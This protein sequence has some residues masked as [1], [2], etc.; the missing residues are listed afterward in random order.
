MLPACLFQCIRVLELG[1]SGDSASAGGSV[2]TSA[3]HP[4]F[5]KTQAALEEKRSNCFVERDQYCWIPNVLLSRL[6]LPKS[7]QCCPARNPPSA[8]RPS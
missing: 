8:N 3:S 6:C 1:Q 5:V 2:E 4:F 7:H